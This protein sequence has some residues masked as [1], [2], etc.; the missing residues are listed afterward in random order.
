[1]VCP[2]SH[3]GASVWMAAHP[4]GK[5]ELQQRLGANANSHITPHITFAINEELASDG[6]GFGVFHGLDVTA[7]GEDDATCPDGES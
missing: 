3:I 6:F 1:M 5:E 2:T 4:A 7:E